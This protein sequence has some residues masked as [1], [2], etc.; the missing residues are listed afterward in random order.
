MKWVLKQYN[1]F[2][3]VVKHMSRNCV[4]TLLLLSL[5]NRTVKG[6]IFSRPLSLEPSIAIANGREDIASTK[7]DLK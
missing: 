3:P 5:K 4:V 2:L 7:V 6:F 1:I